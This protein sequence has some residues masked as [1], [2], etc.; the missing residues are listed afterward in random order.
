MNIKINLGI[1][2]PSYKLTNV[3]KQNEIYRFG[4]FINHMENSY[5]TLFKFGRIRFGLTS[6]RGKSGKHFNS[7][8]FI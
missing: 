4:Y 8:V 1:F 2:I 7:T 6:S 3:S 5:E